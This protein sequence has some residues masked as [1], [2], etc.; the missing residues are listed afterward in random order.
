MDIN[1]V[2]SEA[3]TADL[4]IEPLLTCGELPR[5]LGELL[6][7]VVHLVTVRHREQG[8]VRHVGNLG[9]KTK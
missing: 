7:G 8:L 6:H 9:Q 2:Y 4:T 1:I 3:S 5:Q